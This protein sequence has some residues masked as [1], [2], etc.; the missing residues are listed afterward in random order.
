[1]DLRSGVPYWLRK[2]GWLHIYPPQSGDISADVIVVGGGIS[3]ALIADRLLR[4]GLGV[5]VIDRRNIGEGSTA[6]STSLLQYELDT[7]MLAVA[8]RYSDNW[9]VRAYRAGLEAL[10]ELDAI[11]SRLPLDCNF[12]RRPSLYLASRRRDV[13]RLKRECNFRRQHGFD[14]E[15]WDAPTLSARLPFT[16]HGAIFSRGDA[17]VDAFRLTH[18][19]LAHAVTQGAKVFDRTELLSH[20]LSADEVSVTTNRGEVRGRKIVFA[21]GYEAAQFLPE[22]FGRLRSTYALATE[23]TSAVDALPERCL[24]WETARPYLYFRTTPDGRLIAGGEDTS[25]ASDHRRDRLLAQRTQIIEQRLRSLFPGH[26][27]ETA[28]AWAGTFGE[29][30]DGLPAIGPHPAVPSAYFALGYGG[31]GITFSVLAARLIA[32]GIVGRP[33]ADAEIF[34]FGRTR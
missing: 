3:G 15:W 10:D 12:Q 22:K 16:G 31:N 21:T 23:P 17:E 11:A 20:H 28:C 27:I 13:K 24:V 8:K 26:E 5:V 2:N 14:V 34:G 1:M 18:G 6:A 4:E 19:L 9:A 32:D 33:N 29:S 30:P 7:E 25:F